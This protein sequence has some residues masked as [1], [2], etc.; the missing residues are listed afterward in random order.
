MPMHRVK[1]I[2]LVGDGWDQ[3]FI[4]TYIHIY[5]YI[6]AFTK[7]TTSC[8]SPILLNELHSPTRNSRRTRSAAPQT[9]NGFL[10]LKV[11]SPRIA[12]DDMP[13]YDFLPHPTTVPKKTSE[14]FTYPFREP[15]FWFR[16]THCYYSERYA[17][18]RLRSQPVRSTPN[19]PPL[20][21]LIST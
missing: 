17:L 12:F 8:F 3:T 14:R 16:S 2:Q 11:K 9:T 19:M 6:Y 15:S 1:F 18:H 13:P 21:L 20:C 7:N 10:N 5:I 4:Y